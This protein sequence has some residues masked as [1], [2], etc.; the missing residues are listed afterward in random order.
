MNL[1]EYNKMVAREI[2]RCQR[3]YIRN[4]AQPTM[5]GGTRLRAHPLCGNTSQAGEPDTLGVGQSIRRRGR[6]GKMQDSQYFQQQEQ[7]TLQGG[8]RKR[9]NI[10][11]TITHGLSSVGKFIAPIGKEV[12]KEVLKDGIKAAVLGGNRKRKAAPKG[13]ARFNFNDLV[14]PVGKIVKARIKKRS[15]T[16]SYPQNLQG[17]AGLGKGRQARNEIVKKVMQEKGLKLIEASKY[18]KA[19]GLY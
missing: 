3:D 10:L 14:E 19:H 12:G 17:G 13:G 18:V 1:S 15:N 7:P 5:M 4:T 16:T 11:G 6:L 2:D 9:P 8:R